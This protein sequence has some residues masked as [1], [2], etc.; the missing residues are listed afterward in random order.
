MRRELLT[1]LFDGDAGQAGCG[2]SP[3]AS[4]RSRWAAI[5]KVK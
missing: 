3:G 4:A 1:K 2:A 5:Q